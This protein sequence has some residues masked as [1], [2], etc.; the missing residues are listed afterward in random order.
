[1]RVTRAPQR[2]GARLIASMNRDGGDFQTSSD[3]KQE[4]N[5]FRLENKR[6][7]LLAKLVNTN[8]N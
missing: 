8:K 3:P 4:L 2:L 5:I 7:V 6:D 1:M